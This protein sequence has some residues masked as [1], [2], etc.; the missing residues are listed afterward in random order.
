MSIM[1]SPS[2]GS[3]PSGR[4]VSMLVSPAVREQRA[5]P[6][7]ITQAEFVLFQRWIFEVAGITLPDTEFL[8]SSLISV[9]LPS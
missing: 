9:E 4:A 7:P 8:E 6:V 1:H 3:V 5:Q 2:P